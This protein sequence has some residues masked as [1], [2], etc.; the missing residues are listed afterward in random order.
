MMTTFVSAS[1]K[2]A[3]ATAY[4]TIVYGAVRMD[5]VDVQLRVIRKDGLN[6]YIW[7]EGARYTDQGMFDI[8]V[9]READHKH[10]TLFVEHRTYCDLSADD[11]VY[12]FCR[13]DKTLEHKTVPIRR[14]RRGYELLDYIPGTLTDV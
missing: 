8:I 5:G 6:W 9:D 11:E 10:Y 3:R 13:E 14:A 12:I 7:H 4:P 2:A 1:E